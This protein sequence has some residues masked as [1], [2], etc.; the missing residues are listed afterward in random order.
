MW[1]KSLWLIAAL[2]G[3]GAAPALAQDAALAHLVPPGVLD[4]KLGE[5]V[6]AQ[7]GPYREFA[8]GT[9]GGPPAQLL[10]G[11]DAFEMCPVQP[12]TGLHEVTFR[13]DDE[14]EYYALALNLGPVAAR[15]SGTRFGTFPVIVSALI[16]DGGIVRGYRVVTDDR[17]SVRERRVAY[18]MG[19]LAKSRV[20]GDWSCEELPLDEGETPVGRN[21]VKEDCTGVSSDGNQMRL[22]TRFFHRKGQSQIDPHSGNVREGLYESTVRLEVFDPEWKAP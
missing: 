20:A 1:L 6:S 12:D 16:D 8:C 22:K 11:L 7:P 18:T 2:A 10:S 19:I 17:V 9:N 3:T 15:Y 21:A 4:L 5:P 13:Y 14:I